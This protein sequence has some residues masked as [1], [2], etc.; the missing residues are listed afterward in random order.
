MLLI[1]K[2]ESSTPDLILEKILRKNSGGPAFRGNMNHTNF[3]RLEQLAKYERQLEDNQDFVPRNISMK[4]LWPFRRWEES[5]IDTNMTSCCIQFLARGNRAFIQISNGG[6][7]I[8]VAHSFMKNKNKIRIQTMERGV[9]DAVEYA[10]KHMNITYFPDLYALFAPTDS[11]TF[12]RSPL[13]RCNGHIQKVKEWPPV[14]A[15]NRLY[16]SDN[17]YV[18]IP[19]FS[20]FISSDKAAS[21]LDE[22]EK[23][24]KNKETHLSSY[25]DKN[26]F[27][28]E[29]TAIF[30]GSFIERQH[31]H[32]RRALLNVP[33]PNENLINISVY[34]YLSRRDMCGGHQLMI[35]LPGNIAYGFKITWILAS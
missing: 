31:V 18:L 22:V 3:L 28:K 33:C 20:Y 5:G 14:F 23:E 27:S 1:M 15:Q 17:L 24:V 7:E 32:L 16:G 25:S 13:T 30:R 8:S 9:R 29:K 2:V 10:R 12:K 6:K 35:T 26:F 4:L 11:A 21:W 34:Q 19:D